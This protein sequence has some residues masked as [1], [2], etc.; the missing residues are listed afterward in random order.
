[1]IVDCRKLASEID[2]RTKHDILDLK[3]AG[4][5]PKVVEIIATDNHGV[6]S[7]SKAKT[8][9]AAGLGIDY[10]ARVYDTAV[11]REG[12]LS[13]ISALN[14]DRSFHGIVVGLPLF[15]HL[16][17]VAAA[18]EVYH[19]KDIDGLGA[20]N[21]YYLF[22]NREDAGL[23]PATARAAVHIIE[24][25]GPIAGKQVTVVGRGPT[26]GRPAAQ[27]LIN[28][29]ATVSIAHSRT[30]G[31]ERMIRESEI[32]VSATGRRNLIEPEW[33]SPGQIIV[34]C[35]IS[36]SDGKTVGDLD[37]EAIDARGGIVTSVPGGVGVVTNAM[38]FS[39]LL[40][41]MRLQQVGL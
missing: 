4:I 25:L 15:T 14:A 9:K 18:N 34:D 13:D 8:K 11:T 37:G 24:S 32:V 6:I 3:K 5:Q 27:M 30:N 26:V 33:I 31:L 39:N 2:E 21:T 12:L 22:K 10:T 36:F 23:V 7:Y 35:G 28:R 1:M 29:D 41:A 38:L 16:D 20:V 19:R 40:K 17:E